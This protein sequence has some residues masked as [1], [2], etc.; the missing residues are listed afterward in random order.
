MWILIHCVWDVLL[1]C[2]MLQNLV[3]KCGAIIIITVESSTALQT[4]QTLLKEIKRKEQILL[5]YTIFCI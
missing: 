4:Q 2:K 5:Q 1:I 3:M